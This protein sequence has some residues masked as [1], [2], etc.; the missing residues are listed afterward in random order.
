MKRLIK[1]AGCAAAVLASQAPWAA[2]QA[3]CQDVRMGVVN[4]TDVIATSAMGDVLLQGLGYR[5]KETSA[6]QQIIFS[7]IRDNRLDIFLGYWKPAMDKN[8][9][10]FLEA[11]QVTVL[12]KPSL[13]DAQATLAVPDYVYDGGLK[14]FADIARYRDKLD[15][16][17]YGIEPGTGAN[18]N[19]KGMIDKDQ[20]G[21]K[22]FQ[23]VES[24]EA[25]MLAAVKRA[26][27]RKD[28]V[29]FVGW[30]PHPMNI[31]M[32]MH[33]LTGSQD[34]FGPDEGRASVWVVTAPDYA[35]R[36][37]N[38]SRLLSNLTFT[39]AQESQL[40]V[41]IMARK[42]PKDVARQWLKDHPEDAKRWLDGVTTFD[43]K[44]ADPA[45]LTAAN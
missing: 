30:T 26:G 9:A 13:A 42:D 35:Q 25:G 38:V 33:Y 4:W 34:V 1:A 17:I 37:P 44:P 7:G 32:K 8:I 29:V 16:K 39:A 5:V 31:N 28:W 2:E 40:M 21:L 43:G 14:T 6:V 11:K 10:P 36:C 20:F 24:G 18:A 27:Q 22:G 23:L 3:S 12:P 41:P 15:N 45:N 19:I